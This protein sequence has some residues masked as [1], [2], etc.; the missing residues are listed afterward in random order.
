[1]KRACC[2][3]HALQSVKK[4]VFDRLTEV[5]GAI[6]TSNSLPSAYRWYGRERVAQ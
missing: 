2:L 6:K 5:E 4:L 1:M 3:Q